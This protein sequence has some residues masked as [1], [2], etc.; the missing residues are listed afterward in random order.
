MFAKQAHALLQNLARLP[1]ILAILCLAYGVMIVCIQGNFAS[2]V[3]IWFVAAAFFGLASYLGWRKL[4]LA[5]LII[6]LISFVTIWV[7][8][9]TQ[10]RYQKGETILVLGAGLRGENPSKMLKK[11]LD[12]AAKLL[13]SHPETKIVVS[14]GQGPDEVISEAEAMARY[15]KLSYDIDAE[16]ENESRS[17]YENLKFSR[18][19][20]PDGKICLVSSDFHV[21]RARRMAIQQGYDEVSV[22]FQMT[23]PW[24][25]PHYFLRESAALAFAAIKGQLR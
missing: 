9:H 19:L 18:A 6:Y 12:A 7:L 5:L 13:Q 24:L 22:A 8:P 23:D 21:F 1:L 14:G 20:I 11:R 10:P 4:P 25:W 17:T 2:Q 16:Q 3:Y 15:L